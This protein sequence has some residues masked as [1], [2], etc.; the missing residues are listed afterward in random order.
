MGEMYEIASDTLEVKGQFLRQEGI[1]QKNK[2][3]GTIAL[4][5]TSGPID[6][7]CPLKVSI[8]VRMISFPIISR[9]RT[10]LR[11][12]IMTL[13]VFVPGIPSLEWIFRGMKVYDFDPRL[14]KRAVPIMERPTSRR[15]SNLAIVIKNIIEDLQG[16]RIL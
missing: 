3:A 10:S 12:L 6:A 8:W 15:T 14:L 5:R 11:D 4:V 2:G 16:K 7:I 13:P 9:K 1:E